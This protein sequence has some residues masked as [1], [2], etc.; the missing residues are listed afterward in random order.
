MTFLELC[1][2]LR[3]EVGAAGNGPPSVASQTGEYARL[4]GWVQ[5]AWREIQNERR[6]LFDWAQGAV[7][8]S[9]LDTQYA[10]PGDFDE[11]NPGTLRAGGN[12]ISVVPWSELE[13]GSVL[14]VAAIAPDGTLHLNAPPKEAATL[15]FEYWRTPQELVSNTDEPRMPSRFHMAIVYRAM[16]QYG[17]YENAPEVIQQGNLNETRMMYRL[18]QSQVPSIELAGPLA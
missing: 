12:P 11:W 1:Q 14:S 7:E 5:T 4:V 2:R 10:L 17:L 6:W 3:Q 8:L 15:T 13:A 9:S 18:L 16:T